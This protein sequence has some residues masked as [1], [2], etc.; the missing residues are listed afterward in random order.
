M[1]FIAVLSVLITMINLKD[2]SYEEL[3]Q[4]KIKYLVE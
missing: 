3:E 4:K 1:Y 2:L